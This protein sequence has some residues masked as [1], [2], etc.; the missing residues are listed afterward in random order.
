MNDPIVFVSHFSV[1]EGRVDAYRRL[2]TTVAEELRAAKPLTLAYLNYLN[3]ADT[4]MTAVHVFP[5]AAAMDA[6]FAGAEDRSRRASEVLEP[7]G[8]EIYGQPS[9]GAVS[10]IRAA[11]A[12]AAVSFTLETEYVAGFLR[13]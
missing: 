13:R 1:T 12:S 9:P 7:A 8:W 5:D 11:A 10:A 2:Q 4:R 3:R 6:H